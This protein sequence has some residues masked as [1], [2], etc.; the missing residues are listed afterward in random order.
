V[1]ETLCTFEEAAPPAPLSFTPDGRALLFIQD[2]GPGHSGD[3]LLLDLDTRTIREVKADE[4]IEFAGALSP[5]GKWLASTSDE[6]GRAEV[7]VQAFPGPGSRWQVSERGGY[8]TWSADGRELFYLD[9]RTLLVAPVRPSCAELEA[10]R[11]GSSCAKRRKP[12]RCSSD[13]S[14]SIVYLPVS[15]AR[16]RA[17][18]V[19]LRSIDPL[20]RAP[21]GAAQLLQPLLQTRCKARDD[22]AIPRLRGSTS[23]P[24]FGLTPLG[25]DNSRARGC[26]VHTGALHCASRLSPEPRRGP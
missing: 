12:L 10:N 18:S 3:I 1:P 13:T 7:Y 17:L 23:A 22:R 19:D 9:G 5:D 11:V 14:T 24:N 4:A 2:R 16:A 8:P 21:Q 26:R 20:G 25:A 6:S 15:C